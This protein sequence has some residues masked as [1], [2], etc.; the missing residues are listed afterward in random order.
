MTTSSHF[1]DN[2]QDKGITPATSYVPIRIQYPPG[3]RESLPDEI[4]DLVIDDFFTAPGDSGAPHDVKPVWFDEK[5]FL[6]GQRCARRNFL[7]VTVASLLGIFLE[8]SFADGMDPLISTSKS[9]TPETAG[10]RYLNTISK[11]LSWYS[12]D[13]FDP[14]SRAYKSLLGVRRAHARVRKDLAKISPEERDAKFTIGKGQPVDLLCSNTHL[15]KQSFKSISSGTLSCP[16]VSKVGPVEGEVSWEWDRIRRAYLTQGEMMVTQWAI[17]APFIMKPELFAAPYVTPRELE[18]FS[19][20]WAVFGYCLGIEDRFNCALGDLKTVQKRSE[21]ILRFMVVPHLRTMDAKS[22]T[23]WEHMITC[24]TE[25]LTEHIPAPSFRASLAYLT[26]DM[27]GQKTNLS[28]TLAWSDTLQLW[29]M[30]LLLRYLPLC[31]TSYSTAIS[32]AA[33]YLVCRSAVRGGK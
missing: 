18:A 6:E 10:S 33:T 28:K 27:L 16:V 9:D 19:H 21:L 7:G 23:H 22:V 15:I 24:I 1:Q 30:R 25:G 31:A 29:A 11:F 17:L 4:R 3:G 32:R 14:Q 2:Q 5:L 13:P 20:M 8:Y 12:S 26:E